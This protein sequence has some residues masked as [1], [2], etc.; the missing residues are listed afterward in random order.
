MENGKRYIEMPERLQKEIDIYN[1]Y[2]PFMK[3]LIRAGWVYLAYV[4]LTH[5]IIIV[6]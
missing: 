6:R 2:G 4:L 5:I 1:S 3:R